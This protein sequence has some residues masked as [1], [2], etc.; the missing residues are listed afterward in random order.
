MCLHTYKSK[1]RRP[2]RVISPFLYTW[3]FPNT[4]LVVW[5]PGASSGASSHTCITWLVTL[6]IT[7]SIL[8]HLDKKIG[9]LEH[10]LEYLVSPGQEE[11]LRWASPGI[12][13]LT[14]TRGL[15]T[16]SITWSSGSFEIMIRNLVQAILGTFALQKHLCNCIW[17]TYLSRKFNKYSKNA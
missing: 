17:H 6:S 2:I 9:Y 12:S 8:S 3:A 16:L 7:W 1:I 4:C 11:C 5:S 10:H 14:W 15:V 13:S